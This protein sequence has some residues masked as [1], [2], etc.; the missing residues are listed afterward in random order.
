MSRRFPLALAAAP[1]F[2]SLS[3]RRNGGGNAS[4]RPLS[5]QE[6]PLRAHVLMGGSGGGRLAGWSRATEADQAELRARLRPEVQCTFGPVVPR[7]TQILVTAFPAES[8]LQACGVDLKALVIPFA[9]L[10]VATKN[11]LQEGGWVRRGLQVH[12]V[13]HNSSTTAEMAIALGMAAAKQLL[14]ADQKLRK[15]DWSPRGLPST[16]D[17]DP[18]MQ[19]SLE[20]QGALVLGFGEVG[21]R[22]SRVLAAM[23]MRVLATR[24]TAAAGDLKLPE[25]GEVGLRHPSQL[26]D[27]LPMVQMLFICLP[28]TPETE[29]L[30][31]EKEI[32]LLPPGSVIVNVG[33]GHVLNE[34]AF[35][36][37]LRSNHLLGAGVDCWYKYPADAKSRCSTPV[38]AKFEFGGLDNIVMSPHRA[39]SVGLPATERC[40]MAALAELFNAAAEQGFQAMP[41][42]VD[43]PL[44]MAYLLVAEAKLPM[45]DEDAYTY[46]GIAMSMVD[47]LNELVKPIL[48]ETSVWPY[49]EA[50]SRLQLT[51]NAALQARQSYPAMLGGPRGI[52]LEFV[53]VH[54]KEPLEWVEADLLPIA[55]AGSQL[56]F[57]EKCGEEPKFSGAVMQHFTPVSVRS[58]R[59]PVDGP[60]GDE[61]LGYLAH[62]VSNYWN[63]ATFTVFLQ[64]DPSEHLHFS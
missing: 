31:G 22:V 29:G 45:G 17:P 11:V 49:R 25:P 14:P 10:P 3:S 32:T 58:C 47:D 56:T 12:N 53:I 43:A 2:Q 35:F 20:G 60:R 8:D 27:L 5:A 48:A 44:L 41:N 18:M 46:S 13:H 50:I 24:K 9:G 23:N 63:L 51:E 64:A 54:C 15:G 7:G 21:R 62:I 38:S 36:N 30:I 61:C 42:R 4:R 59:D 52:T 34:E 40:R 33:R 57:Y 1:L 19:L 26:H 6:A 37:A 39:G 55:P 16:G 28:D